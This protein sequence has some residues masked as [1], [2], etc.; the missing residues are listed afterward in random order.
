[1]QADG[2]IGAA[3]APAAT[4]VLSA[5]EDIEIARQVRATLAG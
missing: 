4:L 1:M 5:R 3:A 2:E